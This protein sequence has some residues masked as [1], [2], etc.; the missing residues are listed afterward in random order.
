MDIQAVISQ[1]IIEKSPFRQIRFLEYLP[2]LLNSGRFRATAP[3]L[4]SRLNWKYKEEL[5]VFKLQVFCLKLN[6]K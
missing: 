6:F 2:A 4:P 3:V 1:E 5:K